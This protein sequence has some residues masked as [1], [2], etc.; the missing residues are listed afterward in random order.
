MGCA[1]RKRYVKVNDQCQSSII[2]V[3][4]RAD[5]FF[6]YQLRARNISVLGLWHV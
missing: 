5:T 6:S 2:V 1:G 4:N 3:I